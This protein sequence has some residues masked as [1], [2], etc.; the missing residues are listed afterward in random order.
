[1]KSR[2][3]TG[4]TLLE[5]LVVLFVLVLLIGIL[6]PAVQRARE[7]SRRTQSKNNL[8]QLGLALHNYHDA[9]R[10]FPPGGVFN[11]EGTAFHGW[12]TLI[13]PFVDAAPITQIFD[14]KQPWDNPANLKWFRELLVYHINPSVNERFTPDGFAFTHYAGNDVVFYRNS[15]T[16]ISDL[17]QGTS[18]TFLGGD[19][20]G[21]FEPWGAP[22][23]WRSV[24]LG[25]NQSA[26]GFGCAVRDVTQMLMADGV[27]QEFSNKTAGNI[28]ATLRGV[29][30]RW[31][32]VPG[33]V[34]KPA[35]R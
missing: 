22:Y 8:K 5:L 3:R 19:A 12:P 25:L 26:E 35:N 10:V 32:E 4:L 14:Y 29:N 34:T 7:A 9:F 21:D 30:A 6:V 20:K 28:F 31:D 2:P 16:K 13:I 27:V 18:N 33:D 24:S 1:M 15:S 17:S 11:D 23:N